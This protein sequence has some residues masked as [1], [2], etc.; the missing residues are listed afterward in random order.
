MMDITRW[1]EM[2]LPHFEC[3][4]GHESV[5]ADIDID[6]DGSIFLICPNCGNA[7]DEVNKDDTL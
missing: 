3:D 2:G 1:K 5:H 6:D 4:C 7:V